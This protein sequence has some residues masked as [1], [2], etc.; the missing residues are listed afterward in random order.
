M[1]SN[2]E[3]APAAGA[4]TAGALAAAA[5]LMR[6]NRGASSPLRSAASRA[7]RSCGS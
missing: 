5:W 1:R 7:R 2:T 3:K 4:L 6:R